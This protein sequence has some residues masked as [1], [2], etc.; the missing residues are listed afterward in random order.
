MVVVAGTGSFS[1]TFV[2]LAGPLFVTIIRK[3]NE[4]PPRPDSVTQS[5]FIDKSTLD[6]LTTFRFT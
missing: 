6:G 3:T 5:C 4:N 1:I 2:A